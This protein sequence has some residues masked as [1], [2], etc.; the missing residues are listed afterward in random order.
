MTL[1]RES[2]ATRRRWMLAFL[3]TAL[4][5]GWAPTLGRADSPGQ[6]AGELILRIIEDRST[7]TVFHTRPRPVQFAGDPTAVGGVIFHVKNCALPAEGLYWLEVEFA[8]VV[9]VRQRLF[10]R[11]AEAFP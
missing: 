8:G 1:R 9:V 7:R 4:A 5:C 10:V 2:P 3:I 6:G 11:A